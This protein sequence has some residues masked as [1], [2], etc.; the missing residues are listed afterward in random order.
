MEI[1]HINGLQSALEKI[2]FN[3]SKTPSVS[4]IIGSNI[5][6]LV[7]NS[8]INPIYWF[9]QNNTGIATSINNQAILTL[10]V[11]DAVDPY[12]VL[13]CYNPYID[14]V[15]EKH[16]VPAEIPV[17]PSLGSNEILITRFEIDI[18]GE[19]T[20]QIDN[21]QNSLI[22]FTEIITFLSGIRLSNL[23]SKNVLGTDSNGD[24]IQAVL[25]T[26]KYWCGVGNIPT[27]KTIPLSAAIVGIDNTGNFV[28]NS[29][30]SY[31]D[32]T[33]G[34]GG[35]YAEIST[36]VAD[37]K[38][39]MLQVGNITST[40]ATTLDYGHYFFYGN[41]AYT[42]TNTTKTI[43]G[44]GYSYFYIYNANITHTTTF[45]G[46]CEKVVIEN[47]QITF[48]STGIQYLTGGVNYLYIHKCTIIL[49]E[50]SYRVTNGVTISAGEIEDCKII[51]TSTG[52]SSIQFIHNIINTKFTGKIADVECRGKNYSGLNF[53]GIT[54]LGYIILSDQSTYGYESIITNSIIKTQLRLYGDYI[55]AIG[56]NLLG[57]EIYLYA[58]NDHNVVLG[59]RHTTINDLSGTATNV[60]SSNT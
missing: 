12:A 4:K 3:W 50:Y 13:I 49:N 18:T 8:D 1:K 48:A 19:I 16:S 30:I 44:N 20:N 40:A 2:G 10:P 58:G 57:G 14:E 60:I 54:T 21:I 52:A 24:I 28:D 38:R 39:R 43:S 37:G 9:F 51:G 25:T 32:C 45:V 34:A 27:E 53:S 29:L 56:N 22:T 31:F 17:Q 46:S 23:K 47:C 33:V 35:Q 59:N 41:S 26:A 5:E 7:F 6:L 15:I 36:A 55:S 42:I 11:A